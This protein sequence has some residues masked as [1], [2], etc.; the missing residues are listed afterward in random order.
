MILSV[1]TVRIRKSKKHTCFIWLASAE[2]MVLLQLTHVL[3]VLGWVTDMKCY[4]RRNLFDWCI[5]FQNDSFCGTL[6][7]HAGHPLT[8]ASAKFQQGRCMQVFYIP[9]WKCWSPPGGASRP[10]HWQLWKQE[11]VPEMYQ[12]V[13]NTSGC[14]VWICILVSKRYKQHMLLPSLL[15][16]FYP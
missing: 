9:K 16:S 5:S 1:Y 6:L 10:G 2:T 8:A 12:L 11:H 13:V 7:W 15:P 4:L 14:A 3:E